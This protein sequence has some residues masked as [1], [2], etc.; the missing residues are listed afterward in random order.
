MLNPQDPSLVEGVDSSTKSTANT[1]HKSRRRGSLGRKLVQE[2]IDSGIPV[3]NQNFLNYRNVSREE[4][5]ELVGMRLS[6]WVVPYLDF[7]GKPY[8][9][10]GKHFYRLKPDA[11]QLTGDKPAKYL[12]AK[13]SGCRPYYSPFLKQQGLINDLKKT[14]DVIITEGEKKA[15]G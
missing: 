14:G 1:G 12:S 13:G 8:L 11:G 10:D 3:H 7:Y 4:A 9:H 5:F 15:D 2:L 6:G